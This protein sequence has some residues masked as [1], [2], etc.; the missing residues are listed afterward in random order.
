M[1]RMM[2]ATTGGSRVARAAQARQAFM[3]RLALGLAIVTSGLT[4]IVAQVLQHT[5]GG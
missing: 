4:V 1:I 2:M 5:L 3:L